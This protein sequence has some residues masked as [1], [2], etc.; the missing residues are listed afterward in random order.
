LRAVAR[1]C[2]FVGYHPHLSRFLE[3]AGQ[4]LFTALT[5]INAFL[6]GK[7]LDFKKVIVFCGLLPTFAHF[8]RIL[9]LGFQ[10]KPDPPFFKK[11]GKN[12]LLR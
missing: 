9:I 7:K 6:K 4:K 3:K 5:T 1:T 8:L 10:P 2:F 12:F 11:R